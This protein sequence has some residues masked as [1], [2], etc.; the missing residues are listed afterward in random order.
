MYL[1]FYTIFGENCISDSQI[2]TVFDSQ[3]QSFDASRLIFRI[4]GLCT[5]ISHRVKKNWPQTLPTDLKEGGGGGRSI[6]M[7]LGQFFSHYKI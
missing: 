1:Y 4:Q 2:E 3:I 5:P 7:V 6:V